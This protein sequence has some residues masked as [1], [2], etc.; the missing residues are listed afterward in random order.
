MMGKAE[1]NCLLGEALRLITTALDLLDENG[2]VGAIGAQLDLARARL[3][4]RLRDQEIHRASKG[5]SGHHLHD[6]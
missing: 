1:E 4:D 2:T 6:A 3:S 5:S